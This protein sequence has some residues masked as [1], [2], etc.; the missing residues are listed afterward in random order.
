M[1]ALILSGLDSQSTVYVD[2]KDTLQKE[3][4]N[5]DF[6]SEWIDLTEKNIKYCTGCGY[7]SNNKPGICVLNDDMQEIF[8]EMANSEFL[9]FL[10][11]ISFGGYNSQLKKAVDRYSALGL[12]TYTVHKGE[13]HHPGR[14]PNPD[15]FMSIGVLNEENKQY[16]ETFELVSNRSAISFFASKSTTVIFNQFEDTNI[17]HENIKKGFDKMGLI[18]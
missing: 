4:K 7:C 11:S 15:L 14:Y 5:L 17:I 12:P 3:L 13:L 18:S 10:C 2:V 6:Q 8:P 9:I 1:K 16:R